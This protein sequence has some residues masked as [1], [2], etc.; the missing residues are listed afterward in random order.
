MNI[1]QKKP[2][3]QQHQ[4]P[5]CKPLSDFLVSTHRELLH[6][7][8]GVVADYIPEL[9]KADPRH[10]GI[11]LTTADGHVYE[12]G[13]SAVPFTIQS[14]SKAFVFAM[15]L[16]LLGH[17][18]VE[19][20]IGVEPSGD[21]FNSIR[22]R[23]DNRP[24]NA[25]VNSGAIAC[26]GLI[27]DLEGRGA[28]ERIRETLGQFAGRELDVDEAVFES[29]RLTGDRNR[30]IAFLLRNYGVIKGDVDQVLDVYF[31]QCSVR[32]TARDLAVMAA[33]LANCGVNPV[34]GQ[35]VIGPYAVSRM[36]SVMTS[37]G[38]YDF[39]GEWIYRVGFPA[40]SGVGG[41][42]LAT[43]PSQ[44]GL[45]SFSPRLDE[46]GNSVRGLKTCE[47]VSSHFE[48]HMLKRTSDVR[49][50]VV[51]DY[52]FARSSLRGRRPQE[53][54]ILKAQESAM[55]VM[56]LTGT[57]TFANA[58]FITRQIEKGPS[59]QVLILDFGRV[60]H[61]TVGAAKM[62]ANFIG[63]LTMLGAIPVLSGIDSDM[64]TWKALAENLVLGVQPRIFERLDEAIEWAED[65]IIY[66]F[67]GFT[68]SYGSG[69]ARGAGAARG[70]SR[71][72]DHGA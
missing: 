65:Q 41:G 44:F 26:S 29:E 28:A 30:A 17:E 62:L 70:N 54:K 7:N 69:T 10:F 27:Y 18:R 36:L 33:T 21:A 64:S 42:I 12:V 9:K 56:E 4:A 11:A 34:N 43:L 57:L 40:K 19:A 72:P 15:A 63:S 67:G 5:A 59:P 46:H 45:G 50:C 60:P 49:T 35:R 13:N 58:D 39:A 32:V 47:A 25:M 20:V 51:A 37:S 24:F 8:Q 31:R 6:E 22:L 14:I 66:R 38:M 53:Q 55:R 48:L 3:E 2:L 1:H 61:V 16:D 71:R 23:S 68:N 52:D